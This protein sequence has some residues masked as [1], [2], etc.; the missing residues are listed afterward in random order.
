MPVGT[1]N[2]TTGCS[3][4]K[5]SERRFDG[6]PLSLKLLQL[7]RETD[8]VEILKLVHHRVEHMFEYSRSRTQKQA[9]S[10]NFIGFRS[11]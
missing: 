8:V 1:M 11:T 4:N 3:M 5:R 6:P 7:H 2:T 10:R 9:L